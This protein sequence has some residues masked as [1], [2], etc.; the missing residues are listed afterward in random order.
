MV[1]QEAANMAAYRWKTRLLVCPRMSRHIFTCVSSLTSL[2]E[3]PPQMNHDCWAHSLIHSNKFDLSTLLVHLPLHSC[4]SQLSFL[5][6][7]WLVNDAFVTCYF[8]RLNRGNY[9]ALQNRITYLPVSLAPCHPSCVV[10]GFCP[11]HLV[12]RS[13]DLLQGSFI[14]GPKAVRDSSGLLGF[15]LWLGG[16]CE[17]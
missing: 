5:N 11:F 16:H 12:V 17:N 6:G 3:K 10:L 8:R 9:D 4:K 7:N 13:S 2:W 15:L 1:Q 14:Q